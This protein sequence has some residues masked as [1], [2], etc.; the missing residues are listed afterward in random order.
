[1][2]RVVRNEVGT[3]VF[4]DRDIR[5][6][7]TRVFVENPPPPRL[8]VYYNYKATTDVE[9]NQTPILFRDQ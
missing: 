9:G 2:E 4:E 7:D 3:R 1:M 6:T 5:I 8:Q